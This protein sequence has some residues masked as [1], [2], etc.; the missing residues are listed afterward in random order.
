MEGSFMYGSYSCLE[1]TYMY[2]IYSRVKRTFT[3]GTYS[4][5]RDE[6]PKRNSYSLIFSGSLIKVS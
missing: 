3:C 2:R 4:L 5:V 1:G 6:P